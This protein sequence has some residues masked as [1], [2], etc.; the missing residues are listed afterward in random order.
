M[1]LGMIMP[2]NTLQMQRLKKKQILLM[3]TTRAI[4]LDAIVSL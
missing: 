2:A 4:L 3:S 1:S